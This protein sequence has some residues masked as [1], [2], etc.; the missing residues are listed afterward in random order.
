MNYLEK[1]KFR[2]KIHAKCG[3]CCSYCGMALNPNSFHVDH[4]V[5][6]SRGGDDSYEN[7]MPSCGSCNISKRNH[8]IE[9]YRE[10][11]KSSYESLYLQSSLF[12][13]LIRYDIVGIKAKFTKFWFEIYKEKK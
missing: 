13:K 8:D 5:S 2:K 6:Q 12:R 9:E 1:L 11:I 7:L 3:G 4:F 10:K